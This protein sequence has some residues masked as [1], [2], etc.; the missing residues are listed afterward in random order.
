MPT[1]PLKHG[2]TLENMLVT[3]VRWLA[4]Y[5]TPSIMAGQFRRPYK[6]V[7]PQC[8]HR[9]NLCAAARLPFAC[10]HNKAKGT[11]QTPVNSIN[12]TMLFFIRCRWLPIQ[13]HATVHAMAVYWA[14]GWAPPLPPV[15]QHNTQHGIEEHIAPHADASHRLPLALPPTGYYKG[16]YK[17]QSAYVMSAGL[18]R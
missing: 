2:I 4:C 14:Q 16:H 18:Q 15:S 3:P 12:H 9:N 11:K 7:M 13:R 5:A 17:G 6:Y 8:R 1:V 10:F